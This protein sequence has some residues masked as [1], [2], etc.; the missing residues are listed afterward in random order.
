MWLSSTKRVLV[1]SGVLAN[2]SGTYSGGLC[3]GDFYSD[4]TFSTPFS[5]TPKISVS[6][7][8]MP[9]GNGCMGG[10]HDGSRIYVVSS[11]A[12]S[13]R[14]AGGYS[15]FQGACGFSYDSWNY[16][17]EFSWVAVD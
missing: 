1:G 14:V 2:C 16:T 17:G 9:A 11:N 4:I 3:S 7:N 15:P 8:R 12:S 5:G 13:F 6:L 10:A